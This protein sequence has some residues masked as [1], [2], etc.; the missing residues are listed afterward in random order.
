MSE[1]RLSGYFV[2]MAALPAAASLMIGPAN[3]FAIDAS[4]ARTILLEIR[5]PRAALRAFGVAKHHPHWALRLRRVAFVGG[6]RLR[7]QVERVAPGL[8]F[9]ILLNQ[10]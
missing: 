10:G 7:H 4:L 9:G 1:T 5:L 2:F 3:L 8:R 6:Q